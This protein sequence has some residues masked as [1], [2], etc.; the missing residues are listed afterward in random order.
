VAIVFNHGGGALLDGI[1]EF[2][3]TVMT[4]DVSANAIT[5]IKVGLGGRAN[6]VTRQSGVERRALN[7]SE[8]LA[9]IKPK[10]GVERK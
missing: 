3:T 10:L 8:W 9:D 6:R 5:G 2:A 7:A 4:V 1:A